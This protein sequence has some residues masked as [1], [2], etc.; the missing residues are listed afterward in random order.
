M[1]MAHPPLIL[2]VEDDVQQSNLFAE[3]LRLNG[4]EVVEASDG[5]AA[6]DAA[7]AQTPDLVVLDLMLPGMTGL[8][9]AKILKRQPATSN[10]PM[11]AISGLAATS[12]HHD[13]VA[14]GCVTYFR[15]PYSPMALVAEIKHWLI[16]RTRRPET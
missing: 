8:Q 6:I 15:K 1:A 16:E 12:A 9:V 2:L 3:I 7:Q 14:A 11:I 10:V 13:A 5:Y 4:L